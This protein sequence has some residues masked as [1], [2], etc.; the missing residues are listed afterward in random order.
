MATLQE[1]AA[2]IQCAGAASPRRDAEYANAGALQGHGWIRGHG[3]SAD[4]LSV[5]FELGGI[6]EALRAQQD[7]VFTILD[8]AFLS[9]PR[10]DV[11]V[12]RDHTYSAELEDQLE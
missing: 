9:L 1:P 10:F 2:A 7:L 12:L 11:F 4:L 6:E 8:P 3:D 5:D